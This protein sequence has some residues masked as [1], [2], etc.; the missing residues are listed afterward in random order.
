MNGKGEEV[1]KWFDVDLSAGRLQSISPY[2]SYGCT[3]RK[4]ILKIWSRVKFLVLGT[5]IT[6]YKSDDN[7]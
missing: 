1:T 4:F 6:D 2:L 7:A 3:I 5:Q